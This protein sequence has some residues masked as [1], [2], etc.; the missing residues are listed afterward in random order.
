MK[1]LLL[2]LM[3]LMMVCMAGCA[4]VD[5]NVDGEPADSA[6]PDDTAKPAD[7]AQTAEPS[8]TPAPVVIPD[9]D[10]V[11]D[12]LPFMD[13]VMLTMLEGG[14]KAHDAAN[15]DYFW[16]LMYYYCVN[17]AEDLNE[18]DL[19]AAAGKT[20]V[21]EEELSAIATAFF[22]EF[23]KRPELPKRDNISYDAEKKNY[24]FMMS[25]RGEYSAEVGS[26]GMED[27]AAY[28]TVQLV[29]SEDGEPIAS[30]QF[31]LI[32]NP[33]DKTGR[34]PFTIVSAEMEDIEAE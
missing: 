7:D 13:S 30:C 10:Q 14:Y 33:N 3:A 4:K 8:P 26:A 19:D 31:A 32:G 12:M 27:E 2:V 5:A 11:E 22:V 28:A 17:Y 25:D 18:G 20:T 21:S 29:N 24:V 6:K 15:A 34:Y 9:E 23:S 16:T 1:K